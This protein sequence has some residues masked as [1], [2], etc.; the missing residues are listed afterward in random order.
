MQCQ[1]VEDPDIASDTTNLLELIMNTAK[2]NTSMSSSTRAKLLY[3]HWFPTT[4]SNRAA[5]ERKMKLFT[6]TQTKQLSK[7][8]F[9]NQELTNDDIKPIDFEPVVKLFDV[10]GNSTWLLTEINPDFI[11]FG[12]CDLGRGEPEMG[13]VDV[14]ELEK[15]RGPLCL[16][17][18]RD[19]SF[20]G[21][22]TLAEYAKEARKYGKIRA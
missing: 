4:T 14:N 16:A 22:K 21:D 17:V 10:T 5:S 1:G 15:L 8:Y 13:Y 6:L 11:G 18:E 7:N 9:V 3:K 2:D 12:L 19:F 20:K